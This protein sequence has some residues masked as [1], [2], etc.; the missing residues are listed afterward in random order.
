MATYGSEA[1]VEAINAHF[2]GGYTS[3]TIPTSTQITTFLADG[4]AALNMRLALAGY[5]TP[6]TSGTA[7]DVLARLNNL[8]AAA[9][10]EE[11]VNLSTAGLAEESRSERLWKR[12]DNELLAF[13][14]GDLTLTGLTMA[15]A[16]K[17]R[18]G[19]RSV[20]ARKRDGYAEH[21]D[22]DNTEYATADGDSRITTEF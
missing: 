8:Y 7:Y 3:A 21:F 6:A 4:Y 17:P 10:A 1:G 12:Y 18:R 22:P 11:A 2:V 5:T 13:L 20:A 19:V 15:T 16:A 14:A 9:C